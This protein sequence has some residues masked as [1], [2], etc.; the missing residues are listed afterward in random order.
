MK[1]NA[2]NEQKNDNANELVGINTRVTVVGK[3]GLHFFEATV[4]GCQTLSGHYYLLSLVFICRA[5]YRQTSK[6]AVVN[7]IPT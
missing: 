7:T 5:R 1:L 6:T 3:P 4:L 2:E